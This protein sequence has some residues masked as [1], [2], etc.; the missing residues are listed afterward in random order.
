MAPHEVLLLLSTSRT[1]DCTIQTARL[2]AVIQLLT[3][4]PGFVF[5]V[6]SSIHCKRR[7]RDTTL[8]LLIRDLYG[9]TVLQIQNNPGSHPE[10]NFQRDPFLPTIVLD[11]QKSLPLKRAIFSIIGHA[12]LHF[13]F[14]S[15]LYEGK[16]DFLSIPKTRFLKVRL[17]PL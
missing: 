5:A 4:C 2:P 12:R 8:I 7:P 3:P 13:H 16:K 14:L 17:Q 6:I 15:S 1:S 10:P 11:T 9:N